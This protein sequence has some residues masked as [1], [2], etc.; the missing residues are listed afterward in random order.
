MRTDTPVG[1]ILDAC[2][3]LNNR[4]KRKARA[5]AYFCVVP[6]P[7]FRGTPLAPF[8]SFTAVVNNYI[9]YFSITYSDQLVSPARRNVS[10][11]PVEGFL[12]SSGKENLDHASNYHHPAPSLNGSEPNFLI[13]TFTY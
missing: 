9:A 5:C 8:L 6:G 1:A 7:P 3:G 12:L 10:L 11:G 13:R 2:F 4:E